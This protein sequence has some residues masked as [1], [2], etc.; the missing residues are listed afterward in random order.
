MK[1]VKIRLF[2]GLISLLIFMTSQTGCTANNKV[3]EA[4]PKTV[5]D[6]SVSASSNTVVNEDQKLEDEKLVSSNPIILPSI[7]ATE[8]TEE[9]GKENH[10]EVTE[11]TSKSDTND[12]LNVLKDKIICIDPGH[13]N[14][15]HSI[16]NEPIAPSSDIMKPATV[17]GT[18]GITTKIPEYKLTMAVSLKLRDKLIKAGAKVLMTRD[19]NDADLGNIERAD[20][21]NKG[22]ADLSIRIHADGIDDSSVTGISVLTPGN[23]YIKDKELISNSETAAKLVL[24]SLIKRTHAQSRGVVERND[25][26]GFNWSQKPVILIEMGFM[27]NPAEDKL[28]NTN[29]YQYEIVDGIV[30][31]V[32]SYFATLESQ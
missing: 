3:P 28:L 13:G 2:W 29:E 8:K 18:V 22:F 31:G 20:I 4:I 19:S 26:T 5:V 10:P 30:D 16:K 7:S 6:S 14:P 1:R 25:L 11:D 12:T 27:T 23:Q 21:A 17:Y 15:N 9:K 24:G 32:T